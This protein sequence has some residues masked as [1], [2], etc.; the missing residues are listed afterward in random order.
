MKTLQERI[1]ERDS[2]P[3]GEQ[4]KE[5][6]A[7]ETFWKEWG[8]K[9]FIYACSHGSVDSVKLLLE[10]DKQNSERCLLKNNW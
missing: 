10:I 9:L 8:P 7:W 6:N 2:H 5:K 3:S 1:V 4:N